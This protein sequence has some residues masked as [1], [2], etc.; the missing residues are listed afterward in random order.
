MFCDRFFGKSGHSSG[1][2]CG[3][4][5]TSIGVDFLSIRGTKWLGVH[6]PTGGG[7]I[8]LDHMMCSCCLESLFLGSMVV[9]KIGL[10]LFSGP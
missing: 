9:C 1:D 6:I 5:V 3:D 7:D 10:Q 8:V 2:L 4:S